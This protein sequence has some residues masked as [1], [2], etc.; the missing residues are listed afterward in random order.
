MSAR[1]P[2]GRAARAAAVWLVPAGGEH[3]QIFTDGHGQGAQQLGFSAVG[4][5]R[6]GGVLAGRAYRAVADPVIVAAWGCWGI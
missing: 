5:V 2:S 4:R 3:R 6:P 1:Q